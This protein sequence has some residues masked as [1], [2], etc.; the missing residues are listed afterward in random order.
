MHYS[1]AVRIHLPAWMC[2][3]WHEGLYHSGTSSR[4][5][6]NFQ[7]DMRFFAYIWPLIQGNSR[8]RNAGSMDG[9]ARELGDAVYRKDRNR[10]TCRDL[11]KN[12]PTRPHCCIEET[13]IDLREVPINSYSPGERIIGDLTTLGWVVVR[14]VRIDESTYRAIY[15]VCK[16]GKK[17]MEHGIR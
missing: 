14:G 13:V 5:N 7:M 10:H 8:N 9:V 17:Q 2:I 12:N 4:N 16:C 11:Y 3:F 6:P 15:D 1:N